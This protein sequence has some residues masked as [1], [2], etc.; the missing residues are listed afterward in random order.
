MTSEQETESTAGKPEGGEFALQDILLRLGQLNYSWTNTES[1]LIHL[2]AGLAPVNMQVA[3][4]IFLTLNTTRARLD[5]VER[6]AKLGATPKPVASE[7]L[8]I[9]RELS[10]YSALRNRYNHCIYSFDKDGTSISSIQ[11]RISDR[12]ED[13]RFGRSQLM[14]AQELFM[15]DT[16]ISEIQNL[17]RQIWALIT[18]HHFPG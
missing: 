8:S 7:I 12:K 5:L 18:K 6:L 17:N 11:M 15:I 3:T 2:I 9:T 4:V 14:N 1:L 13:I 10:K 16:S